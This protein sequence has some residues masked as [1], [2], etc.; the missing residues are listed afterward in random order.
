MSILEPKMAINPLPQG[1]TESCVYD[2]NMTNVPRE[3]EKEFDSKGETFFEIA[4]TLYENHGDQYTLE[5]LS[6]EVG[7]SDS[8]VSIHLSEPTDDDWVNKQKG[9][10]TFVWNTE[11]YN[12]AGTE[13]TDA[14]FGLY[15]D[16]WR[17]LKTHTKTS[18][19]IPAIGGFMAFVAAAVIGT[20]YLGFTIGLFRDSSLPIE[21]YLLLSLGL[22][23]TGVIVTIM[24]PLLALLNK[25]ARRIYHSWKS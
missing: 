16:L 21:I 19:G 17:I 11:K 10:T 4:E 22:V 12:P 23:I 5:E 7:V 25:I 8:R 20:F 15:V 1:L 13:A 24:S 18:A 6:D 14:I 2:E 9:K 3:F